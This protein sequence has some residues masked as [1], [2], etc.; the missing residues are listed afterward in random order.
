[1]LQKDKPYIWGSLQQL[2]FS[3]LQSSFK[4]SPI[5][6]YYDYNKKAV[7]ETDASDWT[8]GGVLSQLDENGLIRPV[9]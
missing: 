9:A 4:T 3:T 1:M 6:A 2:A 7:L 5:L 8:S